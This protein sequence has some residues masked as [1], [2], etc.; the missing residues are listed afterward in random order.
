MCYKLHFILALVLTT[1]IWKAELS[2]TANHY[3]VH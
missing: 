3:A 2:D 1:I